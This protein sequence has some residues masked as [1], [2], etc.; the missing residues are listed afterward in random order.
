LSEAKELSVSTIT[1]EEAAGLIKEAED[2]LK[3]TE[4]CVREL[5]RTPGR[6]AAE[7]GAKRLRRGLE[8]I[9]KEAETE[10]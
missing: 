8:Q 10:R 5:P 3:V 4:Y 7:E 1:R 6:D 9:K 2:H